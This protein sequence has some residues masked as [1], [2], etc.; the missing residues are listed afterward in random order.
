MFDDRLK[1]R[2]DG[3]AKW[4]RE[5]HP[6]LKIEQAHLTEGTPERGY[7]HYGYH[8]AL[9]D[10]LRLLD[11]EIKKPINSHNPNPGNVG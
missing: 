11:Q 9:R 5:N 10:V 6:K 1:K 3:M 7:W 4:L 8:A 2:A